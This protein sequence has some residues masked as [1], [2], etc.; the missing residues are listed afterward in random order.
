MYFY[1]S[2]SFCSSL[3]TIQSSIESSLIIQVADD[4]TPL[5]NISIIDVVAIG[6]DW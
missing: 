6:S 3:S 4:K 5:Y 2:N 1:K